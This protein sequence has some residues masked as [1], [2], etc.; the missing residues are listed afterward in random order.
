M[1]LP[2]IDFHITSKFE[3]FK[4]FNIRNIL[5]KI[6]DRQFLFIN[7]LEAPVLAFILSWFTKYNAGITGNPLVYVFSGNINIPVYIF[8]GVVVAIFL[9]LM[10]S[11]EDIIHD[12]K[13]LKREAFLNLNRFSYY[14]SK[15]FFM[16]IVLA[17][18]IFLFVLIGNSLLKI[19]GMFFYFC[20]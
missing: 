9:G 13:I 14:N 16:G 2:K 3:Q 6:S 1:N 20:Y 11:A 10:L 19:E 8:M 18:Q 5:T 7:L 15:I 12:R 17:I 4:V